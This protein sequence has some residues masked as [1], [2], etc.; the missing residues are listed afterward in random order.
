MAETKNIGEIVDKIGNF[1]Q[2]AQFTEEAWVNRK[3][4]AVQDYR[5]L[6][7]FLVEKGLVVARK[8]CPDGM[9][10]F[11]APRAAK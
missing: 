9:V 8:P 5:D 3:K 4:R 2:E 10:Q 11:P 7:E 6:L 1:I